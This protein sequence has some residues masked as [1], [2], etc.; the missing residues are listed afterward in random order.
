MINSLAQLSDF[1]DSYAPS[2]S[3]SQLRERR[4]ER[5]ERLLDRLGHPEQSY[6]TYHIA[7]SKGKGSTAAFLAALLEGAGRVTGLYTSPHFYTLSERFKLSS[8]FFPLDFY[9]EV[10]DQLQTALKGFSLPEPLGVAVPTTFELYTAYGYL[11][12]KEYG[13]TDAV[14]ETGIGGR[15]DATNTLHPEAVLLTPIELEHTQVLGSDIPA[16]AGEKARIMRKGVPSFVSIQSD[17]RA[18]DVFREE[19][20]LLGAPVFFLEDE[21]KGFQYSKGSFSCSIRGKSYSLSLSMPTRRMAENAA[22]VLLAGDSLSLVSRKGL[23][24]ME[25]ASLAG[26]FEQLEVDGHA[27]I[28]DAAHTVRSVTSSRDAFLE[29]GPVS[30]GLV[31]AAVEGKDIEGMLS[32]LLPSFET[33]VISSAGSFK[34]NDPEAVYRLCRKMFPEKRVYLEKDPDKALDLALSSSGDILVTGS[35]YLAPEMGKIRRAHELE[36]ERA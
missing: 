13:C 16:I 17:S 30:P 15:L 29:R 12:F 26:R 6:R 19:A 20:R 25:E 9:L 21:M 4:L 23:S 28:V 1:F 33:V 24:L 2:F 8:S 34:K 14:I 32:A 18:S 11:L 3:D 10:A 31:F 22:L 36:L 5:M 27:V 7:G 35:F